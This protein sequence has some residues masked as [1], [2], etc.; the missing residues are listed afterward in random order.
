MSVSNTIN[1]VNPYFSSFSISE[2][3]SFIS[4]YNSCF[5]IS[6]GNQIPTPSSSSYRHPNEKASSI[7]LSA[8]VVKCGTKRCLKGKI[9]NL[10][11]IALSGRVVELL[12]FPP[13][14]LLRTTF[15]DSKGIFNFTLTK[16]GRYYLSDRL[17]Q[18]TTN[19]FRY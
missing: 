6:T 13:V 10:K 15:T 16:R 11:N 18:K 1:I 3:S 19:L 5:D 14:K 8:S 4:N 17:S 2:V 12:S 7:K 9:T